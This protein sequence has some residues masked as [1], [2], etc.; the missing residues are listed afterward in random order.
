VLIL[1]L[2]QAILNN[3]DREGTTM[4]KQLLSVLSTVLIIVGAFSI[5]NATSFRFD[6]DPFE[7]STALTD[8]GRQI[9]G[10]ESFITFDIASDIF[11][12][13]ST[14]FNAGNQVLFANDVVGNLPTSGKNVIVLQTFDNDSD[15]TT[16]FAAGT[17]AN[18]IADQITSPGAGFFIYFNQGLDLPRLVFSTDLDD[19]TADLKILFR[20][21]NLTGQGG[22]DAIPTFAES[23]FDIT[24]T[25]VPEPS[26]ILLVG[27]GLIGVL[28]GCRRKSKIG[29][30]KEVAS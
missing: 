21:T 18:L 11:S 10:G 17:A 13:E 15:P 6:T 27:A 20:M 2:Q 28:T 8:P 26:T 16:P 23:N 5:A 24:T 14:V 7:G 30:I 29:A 3:I 22:R 12:L 4:K 25:P 9:V 19:N 1:T